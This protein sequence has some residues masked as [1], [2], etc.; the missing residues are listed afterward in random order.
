[1]KAESRA[2]AGE[3]VRR[4]SIAGGYA[5]VLDWVAFGWLVLGTVVSLSL[6]A[7]LVL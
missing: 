4:R 6:V 7:F 3:C 5:V 2:A 1:M